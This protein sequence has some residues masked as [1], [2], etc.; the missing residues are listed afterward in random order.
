MTY[1]ALAARVAGINA[2]AARKK[3]VVKRRPKPV[4]PAPA[5]RSARPTKGLIEGD[6]LEAEVEYAC[7]I[8]LDLTATFEGHAEREKLLK[9]VKAEIV[10]AIKSG[11]TTVARDLNLS[12]TGVTVRPIRME[13]AVNDE[14]DIG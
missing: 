4:T 11:M 13:C 6:V 3:K 5:P 1:H 10:S 14:S 2:E 12:Q 9:K 8:E 7:R